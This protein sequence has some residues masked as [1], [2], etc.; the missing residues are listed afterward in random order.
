MATPFPA[1]M[2]RDI[3]CP[4]EEKKKKK[5]YAQMA[6][7]VLAWYILIPF[8]YVLPRKIWQPCACVYCAGIRKIVGA[9]VQRGS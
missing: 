6:Y 4:I 8:W 2:Y 5:I 1:S 3:G 7:F 9:A